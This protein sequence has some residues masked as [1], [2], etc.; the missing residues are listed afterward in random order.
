MR[1]QR[2]EP[3]IYR[4]FGYKD[5]QQN[6]IWM[7]GLARTDSSSLPGHEAVL[8]GVILPGDKGWGDIRCSMERRIGLYEIY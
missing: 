3:E 2:Q 8:S 5:S 7:Y 6:V 1:L 4:R